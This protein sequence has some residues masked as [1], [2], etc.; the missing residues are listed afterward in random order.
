VCDVTVHKKTF[1]HMSNL[2]LHSLASAL[3]MSIVFYYGLAQIVRSFLSAKIKVDSKINFNEVLWPSSRRHIRDGV[4]A[5]YRNGKYPN[6]STQR[7]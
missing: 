4:H 7:C 6:L 5:F 1:T 3:G 2:A